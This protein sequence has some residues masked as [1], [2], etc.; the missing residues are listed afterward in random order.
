M[1][2]DTD[3]QSLPR[4]RAGDG[5]R[6]ARPRLRCATDDATKATTALD[7]IQGLTASICAG[8]IRRQMSLPESERKPVAKGSQADGQR[9]EHEPPPPN[10]VGKKHG[11]RRPQERDHGTTSPKRKC[12]PQ[13][14]RSTK[15]NARAS[16]QVRGAICRKFKLVL[17]SCKTKGCRMRIDGQETNTTRSDVEADIKSAS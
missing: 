9:S 3:H 10:E 1:T 4:S 17:G 2:E 11:A 8:L 6:D 5:D 13:R 15:A 16:E 14:P 7:A 12:A